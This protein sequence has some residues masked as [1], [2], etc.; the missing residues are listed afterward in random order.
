[1]SPEQCDA[2]ADKDW[3]LPPVHTPGRILYHENGEANS[4]A[5]LEAGEDGEPGNWLMTLQHN[6]HQTTERQRA[7]LRRLV[8]CWNACLNLPTDM[9]EHVGNIVV[10]ASVPFRILIEQR[11]EL[12]AA[13][14]E[15]LEMTEE[16]PEGNCSCHLNPPCS[17][18]VDHS[19]LRRAFK[20]GRAA[21]A[22]ARGQA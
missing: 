21:L 15:F 19:G 4:H 7:N 16:P 18:C 13:L 9:L 1:M 2:Q 11:D 6:G 5:L 3:S 14:E 17:D 12:R 10:E 22:K 8:A 20:I